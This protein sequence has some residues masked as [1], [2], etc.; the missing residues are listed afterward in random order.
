M[1]KGIILTIELTHVGGRTETETDK[2]PLA[3]AFNPIVALAD[4]V[5]YSLISVLCMHKPV[6]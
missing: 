1:A 3:V 5:D 2:A 4:F 6:H